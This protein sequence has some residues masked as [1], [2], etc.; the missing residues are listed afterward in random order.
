M[1]KETIAFQQPVKP[2]FKSGLRQAKRL[3]HRCASVGNGFEPNR[4]SN[5]LVNKPTCPIRHFFRSLIHTSG[6]IADLADGHK[7][8]TSKATRKSWTNLRT[9]ANDSNVK[10]IANPFLL[11]TFDNQVL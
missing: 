1:F 6:R 3:P 5:C 4:K 11:G 2:I 7:R 10:K 9:V 8:A